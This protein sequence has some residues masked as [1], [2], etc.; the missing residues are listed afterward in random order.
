MP[1]ISI[2]ADP[3][4]GLYK[5]KI[6]PS[7]RLLEEF[8][9]SE[10]QEDM[11]FIQYLREAIKRLDKISFEINGNAHCLKLTTSDYTVSPLHENENDLSSGPLDDFI[12]F[13]NEWEKALSTQQPS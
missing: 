12:Y 6:T 9:E 13:L 2:K 11:A 1:T 8:L 5:S 3:D 10:V 4:T 7:N